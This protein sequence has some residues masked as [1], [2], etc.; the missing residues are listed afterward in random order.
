MPL[1]ED[2]ITPLGLCVDVAEMEGRLSEDT[3]RGLQEALD[4]LDPPSC[5]Q[6]AR[7]PA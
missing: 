2:Q 7:L 1:T 3:A 5:H 6:E 4:G